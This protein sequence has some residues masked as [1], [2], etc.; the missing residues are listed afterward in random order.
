MFTDM[1]QVFS[2]LLRKH[3]HLSS[4]VYIPEPSLQQILQVWREG[5]REKRE[6]EKRE[7]GGGKGRERERERR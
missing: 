4:L 7:R 6:R 2:R 3:A 5:G 1:L